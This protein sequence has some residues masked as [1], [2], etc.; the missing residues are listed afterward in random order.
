MTYDEYR[1]RWAK[2]TAKQIEREIASMRAYMQRH[3]RAYAWHGKGITPPGSLSD[4]D[5]LCAL[6]DALEMK[7]TKG[8]A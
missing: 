5:K 2:K 8:A 4:G 7:T 1:D 6:R 3:S